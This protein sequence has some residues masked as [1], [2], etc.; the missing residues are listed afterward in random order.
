M[1]ITRN[2]KS[3]SL[4]LVLILPFI[5]QIFAAVGLTGYLSIRNGEKAVNDL[6]GRL[7]TS[8][9]ARVSAQIE[10]Y[11]TLP[12]QLNKANQNLVDLGIFNLQNLSAWDKY[13]W[14]QAQTFPSV[15]IIVVANEQGE[16]SMATNAGKNQVLMSIASAELGNNLY[17]YKTNEK[18]ELTT[19]EKIAPNYDPRR[20]SWYQ[21]AVK[22]G[23]ATW[24]Q[25]Y[26]HFVYGTPQINAML[27]IY[28]REQQL[29]GMMV[30]AVR[31]EALSK[32]LKNLQVSPNGKVFIMERDGTLIATS[33]ENDVVSKVI[34]QQKPSR[35][36]ATDSNDLLTQA[37][38]KYLEKKFG[39]LAK[40][41]NLPNQAVTIQNEKVFL[42]VTFFK[43]NYGLDWPIVIAIPEGDFM[44]EINANTRHTI[45]LCF[46]SLILAIIL[47]IYTSR[48]IARPILG[49]SQSANAVSQGD[50]DQQVYGGWIAELKSLAN[51]FNRMA[52]QLKTS[53]TELEQR[54]T[55]RTAELAKAKEL[56]DGAN[57]AK[58]EFLANMSHELRT[59]LNGILGYAQILGR[60][61][62]IPEKERHGVNVIYQCGIHL[63]TLIN[64]ILD[65][66]KIEARKLELT[67][68]AIHLPSLI[69]CVVEIAQIR[70]QQ[71]DI[72]FQYESEA[73]L[74]SG[75]MADEKRLR[76]VLINLLG[77]AIKFTDKG[78]VTF[79]VER[80][81]SNTNE[82][83]FAHL[84][85]T[86]RDTGVGISSADVPKLFR[87]F[88]QVGERRRQ[89]EGTGLGLAISQQI[90]QL[91][92]GKIQV[93]SELGVGSQ[94]YFELELPW[95]KNWIEQQT[96]E[97]G[98][99]ISYTGTKRRILV[100]DDRWENR[101]VLI[102][103]LEPLGFILEEAENGEE[104]LCKMREHLPDLAITD[105]SMPVMDG[106]EMLK[107]LRID[108]DLKHLKVLVSSAS[109]SQLDQQMSLEA[110]GDDFLVKPVSVQDLFPLLANHLQL[111]WNYEEKLPQASSTIP[112]TATASKLIFP[113]AA[114]LKALLELAQEGR[115]KK[116]TVVA[117]LIGQEDD[118]YQPFIQ[119]ILQLAKQFQLEKIEELIQEHLTTN[120]L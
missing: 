98:N 91:M 1:S 118:R 35:V 64:D 43:D 37:T 85:F 66:S 119:Q 77:N 81:D 28:D 117:E 21:E 47:G 102:N 8:I 86:I 24:S 33:T 34:G 68:H 97:V 58:S 17:T 84:R 32:F 74:P 14:R 83:P 4:R 10:D 7:H 76:Q 39:S 101:S 109:V 114:D 100:I 108:E 54:V 120:H 56:A 50:L 61:K 20:R 70:A 79:K 94:F 110:G 87:A 23:K 116:L 67:S 12:H 115:L 5:L 19:I 72:E 6:A 55:E 51:V 73:N 30:T 40:I 2:S 63:L 104:G 46:L 49:L 90:V 27:P 88:E 41:N 9:A 111:T 105:L 106:F 78:T 45:W 69:Q 3:I 18:G 99:I 62:V 44:A 95:A 29:L 57:Q 22:A 53:F 80:L 65:I 107:K 71:K 38:A 60:S 36:K 11:L 92:G 75:I 52:I 113:D 48:W 103:L 15:N 16:Q 42:Q 13:L 93:K 89:A 112:V 59:P 26:L 31:L 96:S 82:Q 25:I